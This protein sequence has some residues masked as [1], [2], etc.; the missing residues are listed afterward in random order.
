MTTNIEALERQLAQSRDRRERVDNL[1][2]LAA[3]VAA[4]NPQ[5]AL[6]LSDKAYELATES[7]DDLYAQ[8]AAG[9]L[10]NR[11]RF[12]YQ[13]SRLDEAQASLEE[14]LVWLEQ[15][16]GGER[17]AARTQ[18][19]MGLI[20]WRL[21]D[22]GVALQYLMEALE[23]FQQLGDR[24]NEVQVLSNMGMVYGVTGEHEHAL[25]VYRRALAIYEELDASAGY[26]F[27]LNN[28][29]MVH[30]EAGEPEK[31]LAW[32]QESLSTALELEHRS[33]E[34]NALDTVGAAYLELGETE[35]ALDYFWKSADLAAELGDRHSEL[36]A[37]IHVGEAYHHRS[38]WD[39]ALTAMERALALADEL[40]DQE[41]TRACH[42]K[43]AHLYEEAGDYKQALAHYKRFHAA[44]AAIYRE[45]ADMR[46]K[47]LQVVHHTESARQEAEIARL[48]SVELEREIAERK[49]QKMESLGVLAGG[50]AHDF[51]NLLVGIMGQASLALFKMD[52]EA[53]AREH[54]EKAVRSARRA[55]EL[56]HQML[57]YSGRGH[58]DLQRVNV[59]TLIRENE[60]LL[61]ETVPDNVQLQVQLAE[62]LPAIEADSGQLQQLVVDLILNAAEAIGD[63]PGRVLLA[64]G[65]HEIGV[66]AAVYAQHTGQP[67]APGRY[68]SLT[69]EDD[70]PGM[71]PETVS[72]IFDPFFTT[73][74][75]GRGLSLA[76]V[77]GVVRGHKGGLAVT[78]RPGKGSRFEALFPVATV[79]ESAVQDDTG[80]AREGAVLV[81]DDEEPVREAVV[82]ILNIEGIPVLTA[83][84]GARG[85][86][87]YEKHEDEIELVLLDLSMPG[88]S[89][90]ETLRELHRLDSDVRVLLSSGYSEEE[91][92]QRFDGGRAVGFLQKPYSISTFLEAIDQYLERNGE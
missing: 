28:A 78:S 43:L 33:M 11:G 84:N 20:R 75:E 70:G 21:G 32:A 5:R 71:S 10:F 17:V 62:A 87:L 3:A 88:M 47:T 23:M 31:A 46:F 67:L 52:D 12:L 80:D 83:E 37:R 35:R 74:E 57:A 63:R 69:V 86:S 16:E 40:H 64:T 56:T 55:S 72:R 92:W 85:L 15:D 65:A 49:T 58:F 7:D 44:D 34:I 8:G 2:E 82:D 54:I 13:L 19:G 60:P 91:V 68:V 4:R 42:R 9:S 51:N 24:T 66:E 79:A 25:D 26:G 38:Q 90:Q 18:M 6:R 29:A 27:A 81:I 30:V 1:N 89:G 50:I 73:K 61:A 22:Y 41:Q 39:E 53:P 59:N 14:A 77:L 76:A 48:R 36:A 45:T